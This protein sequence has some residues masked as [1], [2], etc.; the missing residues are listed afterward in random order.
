MIAYDFQAHVEFWLLFS[1]KTI[2]DMVTFS[3]IVAEFSEM[4]QDCEH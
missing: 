4:Y 3:I 2:N 1:F